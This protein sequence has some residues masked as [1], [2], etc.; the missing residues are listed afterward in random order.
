MARC[1]GIGLAGLQAHQLCG[2]CG[3]GTQC[4]GGE[5]VGEAQG[6]QRDP[7]RASE[8][9]RGNTPVGHEFRGN[10]YTEQKGIHSAGEFHS[11]G[12]EQKPA[13]HFDVLYNGVKIGHVRTYVDDK[14]TKVA[15][16]RYV[17]SRKQVVRWQA[18]IEGG[19]HQVRDYPGDP[20]KTSSHVVLGLSSKDHAVET[21]KRYHR[22][23]TAQ[24]SDLTPRDPLWA[25]HQRKLRTALIHA[26]DE[27]LDKL[28][29]LVTAAETATHTNGEIK[30]VEQELETMTNRIKF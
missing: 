9:V 5:V 14:E 21:L 13:K 27:E 29:E 30:A 11:V 25:T 28:E 17:T 15:G 19:H 1:G 16:Q 10:Q 23:P 4:G 26:T 2:G 24:A 7:A 18:Q 20:I 6:G 8:A 22:P 12:G 3:H